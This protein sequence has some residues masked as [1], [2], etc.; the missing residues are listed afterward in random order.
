[1]IITLKH[2]QQDAVDQVRELFRQG[3]K[4]VLIQMATGAGKTFTAAFI[5]KAAA[6]KGNKTMFICNRRELI[7]QTVKAFEQ[8]G[9]TV[10]HKWR[11]K[12]MEF[13]QD[14]TCGNSAGVVLV[15]NVRGNFR[16]MD[17]KRIVAAGLSAKGSSDL[18]G[19]RTITITLRPAPNRLIS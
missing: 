18:I 6:E 13:K 8:I 9:V 12:K 10:E 5:M 7:D 1:M 15:K 16:T 4:R 3:K 17:G 19:W 2:Y 14:T 11:R